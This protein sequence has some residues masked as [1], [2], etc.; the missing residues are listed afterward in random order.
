MHV[1][2]LGL[3]TIQKCILT[4]KML[5]YGIVGDITNEYCH[6]VEN[7]MIECLKHFVKVILKIF[8]KEYRVNHPGSIWKK[9]T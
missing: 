3:F 8:E 6:L 5:A 7:T 1:A 9:T 2:C 4:L